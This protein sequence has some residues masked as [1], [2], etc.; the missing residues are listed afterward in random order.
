[1]TNW[2]LKMLSLVLAIGLLA[3]VSFSENPPVYD[4]VSVRVEYTNLPP[5]LV[6]TNP[7]TSVQVP[8]VG[9]RDAVQG[10]KHS[11]AGVTIDLSQA[12]AG[13]DQHVM[14][15]P[16]Q[17]PGLTFPQGSVPLSLTIEP[18]T[19]RL[20]DI[21]VRTRNKGPGIAIVPDRTYAT[22]GNASDR[23]QVLVN[24][25]AGM[26]GKLKAFVDYDVPIT[27]AATGSSPNQ[28]IKFEV[29]GHEID[30]KKVEADPQVKWTPDFVTV[31]VTTQ[32]GSQTKTVA[33]NP[34]VVGQQACGYQIAVDPQ[35]NQVTVS[36]PVDA[37]SQMKNVGLDPITISG[38]TST[39]RI[40]RSVVTGNGVI[41][42]PA[43]VV[44]NVNVSQSFSCAAPTPPG[45]VVPAVTPSPSP[46]VSV[47]P[48]PR[49]S[50]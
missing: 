12:R 35:P 38:L 43:Q 29:D 50:P 27:T 28:P 49:T 11:A 25:P 15:T 24:G 34:R 26:V 17:D 21:Q 4:T 30:L 7:T 19:S 22:C 36:G 23:C 1:M 10:Y 44:V 48:S 47:S 3:G 46:S 31:L 8:V 5:D 42:E 40:V 33:V 45:A 41:A 6:I 39:Q 18:L 2:R 16:R 9:F 13:A 20:L 37:V 14:A 32:G